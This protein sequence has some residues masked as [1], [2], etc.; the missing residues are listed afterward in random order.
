MDLMFTNI[1]V[2]NVTIP[3]AQVFEY[4]YVPGKSTIETTYNA[5]VNPFPG[6]PQSRDQSIEWE[7]DHTLD[8][9]IGTIRMGQTW[10]VTFMLKAIREG[11]INVFGSGSLIT[12]NNGASTLA[13]PDTYITAIPDLN[14]TP[15]PPSGLHIERPPGLVNTN[16]ATM[17]E[18]LDLIWYVTYTGGFSY[19]ETIAYQYQDPATW[20]WGPAVTIDSLGPKTNGTWAPG[21]SRLDI[22]SLPQGTYRIIVSAIAGD[23]PSDNEVIEIS[24]TDSKAYIILK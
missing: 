8:F 16:N 4:Q 21:T 7:T 19:N 22:R 1:S 6:W 13:L 18:F 24:L 2:N 5:T 10:E 12:F 14:L 20:T 23:G 17:V 3:G 9:D 11:N 15:H